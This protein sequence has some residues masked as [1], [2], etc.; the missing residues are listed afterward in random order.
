[1]N[2]WQVFRRLNQKP[3]DSNAS[4]SDNLFKASYRYD[5]ST[6]IFFPVT[7]AKAGVHVSC[8]HVARED[9]IIPTKAGMTESGR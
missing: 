1:M 3:N 9:E 7:P 5:T 6:G 8:V 4:K 2:E